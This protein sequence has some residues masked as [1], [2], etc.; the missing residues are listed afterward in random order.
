MSNQ[1]TTPLHKESWLSASFC[2]ANTTQQPS[3]Q[4]MVIT[5]NVTHSYVFKDFQYWTHPAGILG[6]HLHIS[7]E[8][9]CLKYK[10]TTGVHSKQWMV[11]LN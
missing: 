2:Q 8:F 11:R 10:Q 4:S 7:L 5:Q 9:W 6:E 3:P 1:T